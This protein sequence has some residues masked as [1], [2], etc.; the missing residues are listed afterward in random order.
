[1]FRGVLLAVRNYNI[2]VDDDDDDGDDDDGNKEGGE[3]FLSTWVNRLF[4]SER[5]RGA[6]RRQA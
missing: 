5:E 2:G 4:L 3:N 1:M 6:A